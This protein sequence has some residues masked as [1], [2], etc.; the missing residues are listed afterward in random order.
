MKPKKPSAGRRSSRASLGP[1]APPDW[2]PAPSPSVDPF[3]YWELE[4]TETR[5][6]TA[7]RPPGADWEPFA[8]SVVSNAERVWWRREVHDRPYRTPPSSSPATRKK[9]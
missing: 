8:V 7:S 5:G 1:T 4:C 3:P 2:T 9:S 6:F